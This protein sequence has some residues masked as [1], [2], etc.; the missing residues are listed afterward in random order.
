L[1]KDSLAVAI[2]ALSWIAYTG[3]GERTALFKA[4]D[5]LA[6]RNP[7]ELRQAHRLV[8][9]TTRHQNYLDSLIQTHVHESKNQHPPHGVS[10]FL[11][12][13]VYLSYI[14]NVPERDLKQNV[15][16]ARQV[17]GW[18]ELHPFEKQIALIA[19]NRLSQNHRELSE[20]E[21]LAL[22]TCNPTW[23]VETAVRVFG[24]PF[25]LKILRRNLNQLPVYIRINTLKIRTEGEAHEIAS[26]LRS[27]MQE[28]NGGLQWALKVKRMPPALTR[29]DSFRSGEI[30]VQDLASIA[31][32]MV[33][34]PR[35]GAAVLDLCSAPGNKT[36]HLAAIMENSGEIC[37]ID[38]SENRL[39]HWGNEMDRAGVTIASPIRADAR[40]VPSRKE[41]DAV[42]V[43]PPC[44]NTGV[45]ARNPSVKWK[46]ATYEPHDFAMRQYSILK[47]AAAH[48][49][50]SGILVYCTCSILPQENEIVVD[51]FL[52]RHQDFRLE[53]QTPFLGSPGLR[54]FNL[55]QR[56]YPHVHD[57]NGYFIAK[58]RRSS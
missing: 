46:S 35:P 37:S 24:R 36:S 22:E 17:L 8:M 12:I 51:N 13:L 48:T 26:R 27:D 15:R 53:T 47:E 10:S 49:I 55:C 56:F 33:A 39:H 34:S 29:S 9:E 6:V 38:L 42:L 43:D 58:M 11:R 4:A 2:E 25:A 57:C 32:S 44:S 19:S 31:T 16:W 41:F 20:F 50:P 7:N 1:T 5:E 18:E 28:F 30:V 23:F 3:M 21:K 45:F 52:R 54:G 40:H 14:E